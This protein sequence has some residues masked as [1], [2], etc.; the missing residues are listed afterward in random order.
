MCKACIELNGRK[1]EE[2]VLTVLKDLLTDVILGQGFMQLHQS[3]KIHLGGAEPTLT[4]GVLQPIKTLAPVKLF[5]HLKDNCV[6]AATKE[7]RYSVLG[8]KFISTEIE[9][10]PKSDL[11]E[12]S[13]S[14]W[15][16]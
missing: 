6:L 12:A 3:V 10:L 1:Y 11:I 14:P 5:D 13:S 15:R 16:I 9:R 2:V 4:L 8:R 7:R